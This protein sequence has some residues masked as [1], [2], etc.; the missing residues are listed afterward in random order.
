MRHQQ[1]TQGQASNKNGHGFAATEFIA[2]PTATRARHQVHK[3]KGRAEHTGLHQAQ[4][5]KGFQEKSGQHGHHRQLGAKGDKVGP[6]EDSHLL[7][8][9]LVVL[10][11]ALVQHLFVDAVDLAE[12]EHKQADQK[13]VEQVGGGIAEQ[14]D[15]AGRE[16]P[17]QHREYHI[18]RHVHRHV[19]PEVRLAAHLQAAGFFRLKVGGALGGVA[20]APVKEH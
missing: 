15:I 20:R 14:A 16:F 11:R 19:Q 6:V 1:I 9:V 17:G 10:G 2:N 7:E 5:L 4:L 12:L 18:H 8:L 3:G 13:G